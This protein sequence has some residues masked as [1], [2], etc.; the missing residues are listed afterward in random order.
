MSNYTDRFGGN[1]VYTTATSYRA[2]SLAANTILDWNSD[3]SSGA[4]VVADIMDVSPGGAGL[5]LTLPAANLASQ[6]RSLLITNTGG[7]AFTVNKADASS[8]VS[9]PPG[10]SY[11][12]YLKDNTTIGGV[13]NAVLFGSSTSTAAASTLAGNGLK[14]TGAQL[15]Q[16]VPVQT[17]NSSYTTGPTDRAAALVWTG[18]SGTLTLPSAGTIGNDWFIHVKNNGSGVLTVTP[19]SGTIDAVS[20]I[21]LNPQESCLILS[22]GTVYLTI[23]KGSTATFSFTYI[24]INAAGGGTYTLSAVEQNKTAYKFTGILTA[25]RQIIVPVTLQ[26]YWVDNQTTGAFVLSV[27]TAAGTGVNIQQGQRAILYC[28]GT[29]VVNASTAGVS[30]PVAV[31]DGGT[32]ATSA[33]AARTNLGATSLGNSLFTAASATAARTSLGVGATGDALF[34]SA[35][36]A[37]ARTTLGSGATGDALFTAA[38]AAAAQTT[39]GVPPTSRTVATSGLLTGG[40]DL[41]ANRTITIANFSAASK[42]LGAGAGGATPVEIAIGTGLSFTGN[43]LNVTVA[44]G[45]AT[46]RLVSTSGPYLVGGGDLSADRTIAMGSMSAAGRIMGSASSGAG[47]TDLSPGTGMAI[48]GSALNCTVTS[49][50]PTDVGTA[51]VGTFAVMWNNASSVAAGASIAGSSI[52]YAVAGSSGNFVSSGIAATGTWRNVTNY[53]TVSNNYITMQ[54][55][56]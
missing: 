9:V 12:L 50:V 35:T 10:G 22:D 15:A 41:S 16:S 53:S 24:T 23:G 42:L 2:I 30:T 54:R 6:G 18:G 47:I 32:G 29:N 26:Q 55:I 11:H 56:A 5:S 49:G 27:K 34:T 38:T 48:S 31:T 19:A 52:T 20:S 8:L 33:S 21:T 3:L 37:A 14:A 1:K 7:V 51:G 43:T 4:D 25:D 44:G 39:L 36:A 40:G 46:S 13:W 28:D 45:V 17:F